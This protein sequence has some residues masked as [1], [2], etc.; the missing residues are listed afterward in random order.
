MM[1]RVEF[2]TYTYPDRTAPALHE[3]DLQ[4]PSG[5]FC[6]I[7][8]PNGAGKSTLCYT[9]T[10]FIP[11]FYRGTC[12]G[13]VMVAGTDLSKT[14]LS[15]LA[16]EVGL[17]F[18]N[19]FNQITGSRYTVR[20]EIAFGLE[21]LAVPREEMIARVEEALEQAGLTSLGDRSPYTLSGGQ[22]QRLAIASIIVMRPKVLVLDEPTS[23]LDPIGTKEV[24][25]TLHELVNRRDICVILTGHK[26]E[27]LASFADR[28]IVLHKGHIV[29]DGS[30]HDVLTTDLITEL[31]VQPTR[32]TRAARIARERQ[33]TQ[34]RRELPVTLEEAIRFFR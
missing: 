21:N 13:R 4:I 28:I 34:I 18:Q 29:D 26:L 16:G 22:Q 17:V 3:I 23:Q 30:P 7:I 20:E 9:L 32:Y 6:G 19:P 27:W 15:A 5:Q 8:G 14:P 25:S 11:H 2:L 33:E 10:G 1:I 24:F 12:E 31:G